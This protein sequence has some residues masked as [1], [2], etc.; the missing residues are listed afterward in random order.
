MLL[1]Y[2]TT[3]DVPGFLDIC[4]Q[5]CLSNGDGFSKERQRQHRGGRIVEISSFQPIRRY[6]T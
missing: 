1:W 5:Y 4:S 3:A 2:T 6:G